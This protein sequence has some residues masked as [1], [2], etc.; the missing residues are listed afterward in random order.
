MYKNVNI[1]LF[2]SGASEYKFEAANTQKLEAA[3]EKGKNIE[4]IEPIECTFFLLLCSKPQI[5]N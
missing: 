4:G 1:A 5:F 3:T 2:Y